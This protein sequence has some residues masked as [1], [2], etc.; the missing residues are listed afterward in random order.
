M[1]KSIARDDSGW[2]PA[3]TVKGRD[4]YKCAAPEA[5]NPRKGLKTNRV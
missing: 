3:V 5:R 4:S 1:P 2:I